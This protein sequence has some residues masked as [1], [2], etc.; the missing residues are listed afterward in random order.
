MMFKIE[1]HPEV[2]RFLR[3]TGTVWILNPNIETFVVNNSWYKPTNEEGIY[4]IEFLKPEEPD[5]FLT[6]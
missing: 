3:E 2:V 6:I 1:L 5:E 4:T